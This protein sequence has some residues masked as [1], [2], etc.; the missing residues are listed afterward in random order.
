MELRN[1]RHPPSCVPQE[2]GPDKSWV[3]PE[4]GRE[5]SHGRLVVGE[6]ADSSSR[7]VS[8]QSKLEKGRAWWGR[9]FSKERET[10]AAAV[11]TQHSDNDGALED[12]APPVEYYGVLGSRRKRWHLLVRLWIMRGA[13][14]VVSA[15]QGAMDR[16]ASPTQVLE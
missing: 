9:R 1:S 3:T 11:S 10:Q 13:F 12:R 14:W 5:A 8:A 16:L 15:V 2:F 7:D 4:H 6:Q